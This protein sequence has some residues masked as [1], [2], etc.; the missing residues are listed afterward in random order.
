MSAGVDVDDPAPV[1][2]GDLHHREEA[3]EDDEIGLALADGIEDRC[4]ELGGRLGS[5]AGQGQRDADGLGPGDRAD[6]RLAGHDLDDL[7]LQSPGPDQVDQVLERRAAPGDANGQPDRRV[8]DRRS[9]HEVSTWRES[10]PV[11][12]E[13]ITS[14]YDRGLRKCKSGDYFRSGFMR[15]GLS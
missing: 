6:P 2:G 7:G 11:S 15:S 1:V 5:P 4:T 9:A 8:G 14:N 12:G 10:P 3:A 13:M